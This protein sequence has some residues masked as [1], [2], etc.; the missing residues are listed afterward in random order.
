MV[1]HYGQVVVDGL[2]KP[3]VF[4][5]EADALAAREELGVWRWDVVEVRVV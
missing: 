2:G 3:R 4:A 1:A 5:S